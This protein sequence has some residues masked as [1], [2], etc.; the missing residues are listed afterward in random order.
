MLPPASSAVATLSVDTTPRSTVPRSRPGVVHIRRTRA[1][2]LQ[3]HLRF[4]LL[5]MPRWTLSIIA[6]SGATVGTPR[7]HAHLTAPSGEVMR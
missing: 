1:R 6:S 2:H 7:F 4:V 5:L 3:S